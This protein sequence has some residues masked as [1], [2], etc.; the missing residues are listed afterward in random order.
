MYKVFLRSFIN[1]FIHS[2][3]RLARLFSHQFKQR[4]Q[5]VYK[6]NTQTEKTEYTQ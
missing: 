1:S 3:V 4:G 2:F 6:T 5:Y